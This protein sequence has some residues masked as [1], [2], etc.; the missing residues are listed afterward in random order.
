MESCLPS[1]VLKLVCVNAELKKVDYSCMSLQFYLKHI[2]PKTIR[3]AEHTCMKLAGILVYFFPAKSP[4]L[5]IE[6]SPSILITKVYHGTQSC[7]PYLCR[8]APRSTQYI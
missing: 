8:V 2:F 7:C 5:M 1:H 4:F 3:T 6:I